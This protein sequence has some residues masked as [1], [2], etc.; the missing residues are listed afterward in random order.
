MAS[1]LRY[2]VSVLPTVAS[3]SLRTSS[4]HLANNRRI[5]SFHVC[6]AGDGPSERI[7]V[8]GQ[9]NPTK[10]VQADAAALGTISADMAPIIDGF[11]ADDDELDLDLPTEGFSSIPE[12]IEDIRQGKVCHCSH[13]IFTRNFLWSFLL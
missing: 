1:V 3:N 11:S 4:I 10:M 5:K 13:L 12:A 9:A 8:N 2:D 7:F 6:H